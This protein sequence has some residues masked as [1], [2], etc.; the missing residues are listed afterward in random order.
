MCVYIYIYIGVN[1]V[2]LDLDLYMV[3]ASS[4]PFSD[5]RWCWL[6]AS[7]DSLNRSILHNTRLNMITRAPLPLFCLFIALM[8]YNSYHN[9]RAQSREAVPAPRR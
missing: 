1:P 4:S 2:F 3:C 6:R 8:A 5:A 7:I 9:S